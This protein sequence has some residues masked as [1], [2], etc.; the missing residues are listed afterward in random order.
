M[1]HSL[2]RP[3]MEHRHLLETERSLQLKLY[4]MA[5]VNELYTSV[6]ICLDMYIWFTY[7]IPFASMIQHNG[8]TFFN[9]HAA[10][11]CM[12]QFNIQNV[13]TWPCTCSLSPHR[14]GFSERGRLSPGRSGRGRSGFSDAG[15]RE[16]PCLQVANKEEGYS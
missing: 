2:L 14:L 10:Y 7:R 5:S 16:L 12:I 11:P 9:P 6:F 4:H 13:F 1:Y 15:R 3:Y 8:Q